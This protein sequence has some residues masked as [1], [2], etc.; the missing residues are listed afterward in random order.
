[1][2]ERNLQAQNLF[3]EYL[4]SIFE[5]DHKFWTKYRRESNRSH[6]LFLGDSDT[7]IIVSCISHRTKACSE[8]TESAQAKCPLLI[9]Y[10]MPL[11]GMSPMDL[12]S[13]I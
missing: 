7:V 10:V 9:K 6:L 12:L 8:L 1:M 4:A 13:I 11:I 5:L 2:P 3:K